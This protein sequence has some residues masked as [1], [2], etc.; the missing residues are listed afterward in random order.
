MHAKLLQSCPIICDPMD[1]D[2]TSF[3]V[4][5]LL[6]AR[7]PESVAGPSARGYGELNTR[8]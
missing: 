5:E 7:I 1:H 4:H 3:S 8:L 6:Q 2:L